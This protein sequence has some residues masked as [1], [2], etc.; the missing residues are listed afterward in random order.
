MH[1]SRRNLLLAGCVLFAGCDGGEGTLSPAPQPP[2][3]PPPPA[4]VT[5]N[6]SFADGLAGW[7]AN[8]ADYTL[9]QENS[10]GFSFGHERLPPPL[11]TTL[12]FFLSG[13]NASDDLFMY[14]SRRLDG[15]AANTRYR[16]D[17]SITFATNA[18]RNC[19]GVGGQPG[20]SVFIKAG[21]AD[22]APAKVVQNGNYVTVDVDKGQQGNSGAELVIIG[23]F[24]QDTP[25]DC[26]NPEYRR[27]TLSSGGNGP[28]VT[29]D[30]G[31]RLW[32]VIGT[33][34]GFESV[35]RIYY[36]NGSITLTPV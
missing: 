19:A 21:A 27:K 5:L 17:T 29:S 24:A 3:A 6:F 12:G 11:A 22:S 8:Y 4:P 7:E 34:S 16:V 2:P 23:N 14:I 25:G 35:T 20:E 33:E 10:I 1:I 13:N 9:G 28:V 15:L 36:L 18:A 32:L 26:L 30:S 31:G